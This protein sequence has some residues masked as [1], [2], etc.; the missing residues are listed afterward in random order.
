VKF[1]DIFNGDA[2]GICA[3]H[4]LRLSEPRDSVL[5][6]GVKRDVSLL[7]KVHPGQGDQ[8]TVLDVSLDT[9]RA[10][11]LAMLERGA[12]VC[13]FDHHF[14]GDIPAHPRLDAQIDTS[15]EIC[16]SL[17][18]DRHLKG[19]HR[20][21]A[22]AAAYGD[23]LH[24]AAMASAAHLGLDEAQLSALR[25]VGECLNYN[26]YGNS[27]A[28]LHF[29]PAEL[30]LRMRP[31]ADPFEFHARAPEIAAL[32]VAL[33]SDLKKARQLP[34][35]DLGE[36]SLLVTLPDADWCRRISGVLGN[37]LARENPH[38]IVALLGRT[39]G[40]F[41]VS[42]RGPKTANVLGIARL[43]DSGGGRGRAAGISFLPDRSLP[44]FLAQLERD[45]QP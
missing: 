41:R 14:A 18:V 3:L 6:S 37:E 8:V 11:L 19:E 43:F 38:R 15:A 13:Y 25:E 33:A 9:N 2:D 35:R 20:A 7:K 4:Q 30:Y 12:N 32:R 21:W 24:E 27:P 39:E 28:D 36:S 45:F 16:T 26:A 23:N 29:D 31:F 5:V 1:Y 34:R 17:I 42:L 22:V 10:E 44:E 40:G